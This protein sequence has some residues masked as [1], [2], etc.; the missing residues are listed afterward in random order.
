MNLIGPVQ[1]KRTKPLWH[2]RC[3]ETHIKSVLIPHNGRRRAHWRYVNVRCPLFEGH[4]GE[5]PD[6]S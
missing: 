3:T 2:E 1:H 6:P 5:H 4:A